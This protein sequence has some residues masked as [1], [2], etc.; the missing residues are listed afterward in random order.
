MEVTK[1]LKKIGIEARPE[2][3]FAALK[4]IQLKTIQSIAYENLSVIF[5]EPMHIRE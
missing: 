1:F 4:E 5:Q 3:S 2:N